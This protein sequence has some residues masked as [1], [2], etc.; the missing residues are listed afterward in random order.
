MA[1]DSIPKLLTLK[2][3]T[4]RLRISDSTLKRYIMNGLI[5]IVRITDRKRYI[6]QEDLDKFIKEHT[7]TWKVI[8][9]EGG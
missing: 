4:E 9:N 1:E 5:P 7:G 8:N 2:E 3:V 6:R